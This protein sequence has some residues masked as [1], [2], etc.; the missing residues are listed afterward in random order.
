[1]KVFKLIISLVIS[2]AAGA[3][4]S[5]ATIP[6]IPGW[7]AGLD[8]PWFN[9]PNWV[10]GPVWTTLYVLMAIALYLVW[11]AKVKTD[12]TRVYWLF[13]IQLLLN[14][15]WSIVF[16]GLHAPWLAVFVIV[17]LLV[18]LIATAYEF[19]KSSQ[20]AG[21]LLFPYIA[22]VLFAALLNIAVAFL[23]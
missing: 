10:F 22:W 15:S 13:G 20:W 21:V 17:A 7:Y 14:A 1:M 18:T 8:K 4:G 2:F 16:F 5:L 9:P 23:N 12:K 6:N 3:V 19:S 11:T